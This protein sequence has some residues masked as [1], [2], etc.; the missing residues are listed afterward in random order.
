MRPSLRKPSEA[1][2]E[3]VKKKGE[4]KWGQHESLGVVRPLAGAFSDCGRGLR[5]RAAER[6]LRVE[7]R[8]FKVWKLGVK[9]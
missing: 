5:L 8:G 2:E 4:R 3:E 7:G 6:E 9:T 1:A